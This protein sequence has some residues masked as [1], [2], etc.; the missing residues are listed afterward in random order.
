MDEEKSCNSC[1]AA[2]FIDDRETD[3][4]ASCEEDTKNLQRNTDL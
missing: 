3:V 2:K 1:S 4:L